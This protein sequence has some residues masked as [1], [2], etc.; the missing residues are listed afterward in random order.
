MLDLQAIG[1][2]GQPTRQTFHVVDPAKAV[3]VDLASLFPRE[4]HATGKYHP[5]GLQLHTIV[6]GQVSCWGLCEQGQWWGLVTYEIAY[7]AKRKAVTHWV[8][9]WTLRLT[10]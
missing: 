7:G 4:P 8:P 10:A 3:L 2:G 9:A 1:H 5:G 6:T